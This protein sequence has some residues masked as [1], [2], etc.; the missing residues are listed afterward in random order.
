LIYRI[1][2]D[3]DF[4]PWLT[5]WAFSTRF[6]YGVAMHSVPPS[7][8]YDALNGLVLEPH[9]PDLTSY[10]YRPMSGLDM[11][12]F[13]IEYWFTPIIYV[14]IPPQAA[15]SYGDSYLIRPNCGLPDTGTICRIKVCNYCRF[16]DTELVNLTVTVW[17]ANPGAGYTTLLNEVSPVPDNWGWLISEL[18][19]LSL[20]RQDLMVVKI[21]FSANS[22]GT[23]SA[24][25]Q[26]ASCYIEI[27][28][29]RPDYFPAS[30]RHERLKR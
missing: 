27:E 10:L 11:S 21:Q 5:A 22:F 25:P 12:Y 13:G 23:A 6:N 30:L 4:R 8:N 17:Q 1:R 9:I 29:T 7:T 15:P 16:P 20:N 26:V 24:N 3:S 2:P 19:G 14:T 18:T 28:D